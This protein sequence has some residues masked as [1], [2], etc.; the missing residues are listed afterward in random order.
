M[1][2]SSRAYRIGYFVGLAV[3]WLILVGLLILALG[4]LMHLGVK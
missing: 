1:S 2:K 4:F 3:A